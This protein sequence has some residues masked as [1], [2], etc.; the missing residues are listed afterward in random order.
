[1]QIIYRNKIERGIGQRIYIVIF[2]R[3]IGRI[4]RYWKIKYIGRYK[5]KGGE[6]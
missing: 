6:V 1:M 2:D 4:G 5:G 3:Y